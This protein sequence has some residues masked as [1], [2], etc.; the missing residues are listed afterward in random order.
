[1]PLRGSRAPLPV[2][3][4]ATRPSIFLLQAMLG[5]RS[6]RATGERVFG[7]S[8]MGGDDGPEV[9][10]AVEAEDEI[11][12]AIEGAGGLRAIL[13]GGRAAQELLRD[14]GGPEPWRQLLRSLRLGPRVG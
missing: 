14:V 4:K 13:A 9:E 1:M 11:R 6:L 2:A 12:A 7:Y 3:P 5:G 8:C 10:A